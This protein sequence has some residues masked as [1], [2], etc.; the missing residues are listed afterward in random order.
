MLILENQKKI[1]LKQLTAP[2]NITIV[3]NYV[4]E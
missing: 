3:L 1:Q 2:F 4:N